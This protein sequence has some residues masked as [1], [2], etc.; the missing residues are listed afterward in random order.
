MLFE[1]GDFVAAV[2]VQAD[3]ADPEDVRPSDELRNDRQDVVSQLQVFRF[4]WINAEPA[5]M[6]QPKIRRA[7]RFAFGQ[8]REVISKTFD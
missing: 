2:F 6:R 3:L 5:E 8:E 4:F 7:L 1:H